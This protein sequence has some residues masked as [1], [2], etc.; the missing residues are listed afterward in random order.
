MEGIV[1]IME[2]MELIDL[3]EEYLSMLLTV[4][5]L[6][7]ETDKVINRAVQNSNAYPEKFMIAVLLRSAYNS[8]YEA[9]VDLQ[10]ERKQVK[11]AIN[12]YFTKEGTC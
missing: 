6:R 10:D 8:L 9:V 2:I 4:I 11:K 3:D 12:A 7:D 5:Q 1:K